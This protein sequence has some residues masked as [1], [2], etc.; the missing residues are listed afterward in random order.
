M[1]IAKFFKNSFFYRI[2]LVAASGPG[3]IEIQICDLE[4][5]LSVYKSNMIIMSFQR[6]RNVDI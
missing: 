3:T 1:N 6:K 5:M 4:I 2:P